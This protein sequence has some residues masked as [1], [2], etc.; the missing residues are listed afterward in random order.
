[1]NAL[2]N[3]LNRFMDDDGRINAWPG[4]RAKQMAILD[5]L[6]TN[7]ERDRAYSEAEIN[8]T[9]K[10]WHTFGDWSLLRRELVDSNRLVRDDYGHQYQVGPAAPETTTDEGS[11]NTIG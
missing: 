1:M 2:P 5:Y 10:Q 7:F 4:K 8:E 11:E 3:N 6:V 9:L